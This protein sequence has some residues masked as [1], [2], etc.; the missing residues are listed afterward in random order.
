MSSVTSVADV[1]KLSTEEVLSDI[2]A[3]M[4][5]PS[6]SSSVPLFYDSYHGCS[7]VKVTSVGTQTDEVQEPKVVVCP[8][9]KC[10]GKTAAEVLGLFG[11]NASV[12]KKSLPSLMKINLDPP[13][14]IKTPNSADRCNVS[15]GPPSRVYLPRSMRPNCWNC[16][17]PGH[18]RRDCPWRKRGVNRICCYLCGFAGVTA[19]SCP[20]CGPDW[21]QRGPYHRGLRRHFRRTED[22]N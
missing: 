15:E 22:S 5:S 18:E 12:S 8:L 9:L 10:V 20:K 2:D 11:N 7:P 16:S 17:E 4:S 19:K 6:S 1:E 3:I 21:F 13:V 14:P